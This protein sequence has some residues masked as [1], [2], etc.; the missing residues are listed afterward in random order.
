MISTHVGSNSRY[1]KKLLSLK[2]GE[3][4]KM[5]G[6][7]LFFFL[8]PKVTDY[9]FLAQGIG[10][11]PFRSLLLHIKK[12]KIDV[13][14]TLVHVGKEHTF[15]E[16][17]EPAA[18]ESYYVMT[19]EAFTATVESIQKKPHQLY[20]ISGSPRFVRATKQTLQRLGIKKSQMKSDNFL[21][22]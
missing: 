15:R 7:F 12:Q 21:G 10:I 18:S 1:K 3:T 16:V 4:I 14:T 5:F 11:T 9:V 19:P 2:V 8:R 20:F 6:P 13:R 17:T 22:Y